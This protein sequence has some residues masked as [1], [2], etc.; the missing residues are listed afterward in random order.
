MTFYRTTDL[1][2][3][4]MLDMSDDW[5]RI[6]SPFEDS[7]GQRR[8]LETNWFTFSIAERTVVNRL[9]VLAFRLKTVHSPRSIRVGRTV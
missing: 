7:V 2:L 9:I 3:Y 6:V 5:N 4:L 8:Y 1:L